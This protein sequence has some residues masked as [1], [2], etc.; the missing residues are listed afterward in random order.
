V[1]TTDF[2]MDELRALLAN[3]QEDAGDMATRIRVLAAALDDAAGALSTASGQLA[4]CG[5]DSDARVAAAI[6]TDARRILSR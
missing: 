2:T 6:A 3:Y 5:L 4:L 1:N